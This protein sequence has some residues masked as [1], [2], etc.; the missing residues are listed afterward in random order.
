LT[1]EVESLRRDLQ[2]AGERVSLQE[3]GDWLS[4]FLD[5]VA[6]SLPSASRP[7]LVMALGRVEGNHAAPVDI[8]RECIGWADGVRRSLVEWCA[9]HG[10]V[11][12]AGST[13]HRLDMAGVL[14]RSYLAGGMA[15][16]DFSDLPSQIDRADVLRAMQ[17]LRDALRSVGV[18]DET[19]RKAAAVFKASDVGNTTT[20]GNPAERER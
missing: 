14:S 19:F 10:V 20:P 17:E 6:I 9:S 1:L 16:R 4:R 2:L 15:D 11:V 5:E 3:I 8:L 12:Q 7:S 18:T 13:E